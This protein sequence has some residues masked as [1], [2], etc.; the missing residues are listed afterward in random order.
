MI[1]ICKK[2]KIVV[3]AAVLAVMLSNLCA[4]QKIALYT[5]R[6]ISTIFLK[7][8][9]LRTKDGRTVSIDTAKKNL[10][11]YD[12]IWCAQLVAEYNRPAWR[13]LRENNR[14][15][16]M[17]HYVGGNSSRASKETAYL[18][19]NYINTYHPEW[20]LLK[21]AGNTQ[22]EDY[23]DENKRIRWAPSNPEHRYYNRFYLD[24]GNEHFQKWAA[25]QFVELVSG[26]KQ[27]LTYAY[28]GLAMDNVNIGLERWSGL[29]AR[30]PNWKYGGNPQAW[31]DAF[32][33]YLKVIKKELNK[34]GFTLMV[35]HNLDYGSD[36]DDRYWDI[37]LEGADGIMTERTIKRTGPYYTDD[38]WLLSIKRHE[39]ILNKGLINWWVCYPSK[40]S[41]SA[42]DEFL[43]YY[44]SWLLIKKQG[45]SF[46]YSTRGKYAHI[47][48]E[49]PWYE[50]YDLALGEA[51]SSRYSK[52]AC[53]LRDYK[54]GKI[55]VNPTDKLQRI[56]I[57]KNKQW[58]DWENKKAV[59]ELEIPPITGRIL[60]PTPY[61]EGN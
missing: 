51:I 9:E 17:L 18:N 31:H 41:P 55:V 43:Y 13:F 28:D 61:T 39:E 42:H 54:N 52:G 10:G 35:N 8:N 19:Y 26:R 47:H 38:K 60:L 14:E 7:D 46:F 40:S 33:A 48:P 3:F 21:D 2:L 49:V 56:V 6:G 37:L 34:N 59:T 22:P 15:Q 16:V 32:F 53:W 44:C 11:K 4:G 27:N 29:N 36:V 50:E 12:A 57:D 45:L 23:R 1:N 30:C 5:G 24:I 20:F 25:S 58:L